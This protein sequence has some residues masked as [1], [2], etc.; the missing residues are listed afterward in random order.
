MHIN[1]AMAVFS[2]VKRRQEMPVQEGR[3]VVG[4]EM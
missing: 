1:W 4:K 3:G 2:G